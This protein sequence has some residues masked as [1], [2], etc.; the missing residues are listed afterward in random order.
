MSGPH[1]QFGAAGLVVLQVHG[2]QAFDH[3]ALPLSDFGHID[4]DGTRHRAEPRGVMRQIRDFRAP[5][6]VLAGEAVDVGTGAADPSSLHD[7]GAS[8]GS[9]HV[10]GQVLAALSTAKDKRF[11]PFR[12]SHGYLHA[13]AD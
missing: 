12:L 7:G 4:R 2:D 9:R 6:L 3:I 1:D 11:K 8:T 13:L 5:D 10:P